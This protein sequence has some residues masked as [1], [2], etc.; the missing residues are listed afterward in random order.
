[1]T[2]TCEEIVPCRSA[3]HAGRERVWGSCGE[4]EQKFG[5]AGLINQARRLCLSFLS[6]LSPSQVSFYRGGRGRKELQAVRTCS[7]GGRNIIIYTIQTSP[8]DARVGRRHRESS[9]GSP[10]RRGTG[11]RTHRATTKHPPT[12]VWGEGVLEIQQDGTC[13]EQ[14]V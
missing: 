1:M 13:A 7:G 6:E 14:Y 8:A 5:V 11:P 10:E 9:R 3:S 12:L 4:R 2:P